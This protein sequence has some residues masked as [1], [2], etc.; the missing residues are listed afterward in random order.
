MT[1]GLE[2]RK[3]V[4]AVPVN[5]SSRHPVLPKFPRELRSI[6]RDPYPGERQAK[7][8]EPR[9]SVTGSAIER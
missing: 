2:D 5:L 6:S 7:P 3:G 8:V 1:G 9:G 4:T